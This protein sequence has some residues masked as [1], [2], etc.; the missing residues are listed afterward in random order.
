MSPATAADSGRIEETLAAVP[1]L[2][3]LSSRQRARLAA[4]ATTRSYEP[5]WVIVRQGDTSMALYVILSG[6]VRIERESDRGSAIVHEAGPRGFFGEMGLIDDL[7]RSA[8]VVAQEPTECALLAKWDFQN[9][10]RS[11]P[12]IALALLP[13]LNERIRKLNALVAG[14]P[15]GASG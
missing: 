3:R 10:L 6:S 4:L 14:E 8:T 13:V 5:E 9:E 11:D 2:A 15:E 12:E 1:L 7:P